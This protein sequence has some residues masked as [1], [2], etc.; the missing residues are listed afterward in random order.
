MF[1]RTAILMA[2]ILILT[3]I[4]RAKTHGPE[5]AYVNVY[6]W[7][8]MIDPS[9]LDDFETETGIKV[10]Y[11]LFDSN[12]ILEAKLVSGHSG[13]DVVFP[14]AS[15]YLK[16][17]IES[18]V[19]QPIQKELIPNYANLDPDILKAIQ[20]VDPGN[21]YGIPFFWGT[22]G[23][24]YVEEEIK[25]HM[26]NAPVHSYRML[27]DP[28]VVKNFAK[29]GVTLLEEAVDV[30]PQTLNFL[31]RDRFSESQEDLEAAQEHLKKVRPHI[32]RFSSSRFVNELVGGESCIA[33]AW[34][35]EAQQ[36]QNRAD[37]ANRPVTI[38]YVIPEEG[39]TLW[40]DGIAI[41]KDA[42]HPKNAHKFINFL[43]RPD[44][45]ARISNFS[46]LGIANRHMKTLDPAVANDPT[47]YPPA[48]LKKKLFLDH[49][50][51]LEFERK[52]TRAWA[53]LRF[54]GES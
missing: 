43:L 33:Q 9:V 19:Y 11:D 46:R 3:V 17:Q 28:A 44:I 12:D 21:V 20:V 53:Q 4:F 7:Y 36:A 34:S 38:H 37:E 18:G 13:Y 51:S 2:F 32:R 30:Y 39:T 52:R 54:S 42:P 29:C 25:K 50:P 23:F 5:E 27:F 6:N 47:I 14:T 16:P 1:Q 31:G 26:P 48:H 15:P 49:P 8:G 40:I 24:A 41:P 45:S 10:R 35:G 22:L